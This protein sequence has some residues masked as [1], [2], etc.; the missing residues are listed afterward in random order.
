MLETIQDVVFKSG[1]TLFDTTEPLET[2]Y[3]ILEGAV[4]LELVL[5]GKTIHLEIGAN[6]F[7]GD[8]AVAVGPKTRGGAISYRGR[9]V[10][11]GDVTAVPIPITEIQQELEAC[12]PLMKAWFASFV[13]RVL[14]VT[15]KLSHTHASSG[16]S[17]HD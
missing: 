6:H 4:D 10:A 17:K 1:D 2:A 12:S 9:A 8:A 15:E 16:D 13:S 3:F 14:I 5:N 11:R 7:V